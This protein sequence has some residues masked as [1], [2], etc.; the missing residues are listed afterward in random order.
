MTWKYDSSSLGA[1]RSQV[2]DLSFRLR[3]VMGAE[4]GNSGLLEGR[5]TM[6]VVRYAELLDDCVCVCAYF[7]QLVSLHVAW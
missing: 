6:G 2:H 3:S 1:S 5:L 7:L 4:C